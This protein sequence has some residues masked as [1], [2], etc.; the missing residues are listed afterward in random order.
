MALRLPQ[1]S[2]F[3]KRLKCAMNS[4]YLRS[5]PVTERKQWMK[6]AKECR[7]ID[8]LSPQMQMHLIKSEEELLEMGDREKK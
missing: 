6:A 8:D 2:E 5:L 7:K 4:S 1:D 3:K